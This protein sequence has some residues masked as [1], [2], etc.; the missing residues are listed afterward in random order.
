MF[1]GPAAG[2]RDRGNPVFDLT[3]SKNGDGKSGTIAG[4]SIDGCTSRRL[5]K[6]QI[7]IQVHSENAEAAT[8]WVGS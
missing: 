6:G 8:W 2:V 4:S 5:K 1:L 3:L 7:Y